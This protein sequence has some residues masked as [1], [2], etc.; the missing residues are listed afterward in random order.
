MSVGVV[1]P[2]YEGAQDPRRDEALA[3]VRTWWSSTYPDWQLA[4]GVFRQD[5]GPWC[6]GLAVHRGVR[7][8]DAD[9]IVVADA[10]V[11]C[12]NV[13]DAVDQI[14]RLHASWAIPHRMVCRLTADAT[15]MFLRDG[16]RPVA[17]MRPGVPSPDFVEV[18]PGVAGGGLVVLPRRLLADVPI[19]PR[20]RGWG[21]E[22]YAWSRALTM[23]SGHPWRGQSPCLHLWHQPQVRLTRG[24]GSPASVD[25]FH[26]Y[27]RIANVP[28][29]LD[30][31][32]E[33]KRE[34]SDD[35]R[36]PDGET[37][38]DV[39]ATIDPIE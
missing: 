23:I 16:R 8:L 35:G 4:M 38:S 26:R 2:W 1:L 18:Y 14:Q 19:D 9:I 34:L 12:D 31:V 39:A 33:A 3:Y 27:H 13:H 22:D 10:D 6:K 30:L 28:G 36:Q 32:E 11:I 5:E 37:L 7:E 20:F 21:Q 17:T 25:L 15:T 29:M 24:R